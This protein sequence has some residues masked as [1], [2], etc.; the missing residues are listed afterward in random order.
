MGD[1]GHTDGGPWSHSCVIM[2]PQLRDEEY[3]FG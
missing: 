2:V 1:N 3:I